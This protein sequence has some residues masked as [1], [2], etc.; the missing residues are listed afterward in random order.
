MLFSTVYAPG[1]E[2]SQLQT[3]VSMW[4]LCCPYSINIFIFSMWSLH[5][6]ASQ[7]TYSL[8]E[9]RSSNV[10]SSPALMPQN[11]NSLP[12][13]S[14]GEWDVVNSSN[15]IF[16]SIS[17]TCHFWA[18]HW[19]V[20]VRPSRALFSLWH[21]HSQYSVLGIV[22]T[23]VSE[24]HNCQHCWFTMNMENEQSINICCLSHQ[25]FG[26]SCYYSIT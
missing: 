14:E 24:W 5:L 25:D 2:N 9:G 18:K 21:G 23:L 22:S 19:I 11:K 6:L 12:A 17:K 8:H 1:L 10:F 4:H 15:Q 3:N 13:P 7:N 16:L 26:I 20:S